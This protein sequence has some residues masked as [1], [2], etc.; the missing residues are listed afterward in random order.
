MRC[1]VHVIYTP[2]SGPLLFHFGFK[3]H[4]HKH[5]FPLAV[6]AATH[7]SVGWNWATAGTAVMPSPPNCASWS[8]FA[9]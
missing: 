4:I 2:F 5:N 3:H 8:P 1:L 9:V 6:P 7:C